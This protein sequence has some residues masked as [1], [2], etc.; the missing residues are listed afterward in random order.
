MQASGRDTPILLSSLTYFSYHLRFLSYHG[1]SF[2]V[3]TVIIWV[4]IITSGLI[5]SDNA[6][7]LSVLSLLKV[8]SPKIKLMYRRAQRCGSGTGPGGGDFD[9]WLG[10]MPRCGLTPQG[11]VCR[12]QL[13][14]GSLSSLMYFSLPLHSSLK[15]IKVNICF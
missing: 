2:F 6:N 4:N 8:Q 3:S 12:R 11:D 13:I 15:S 5:G 7:F 10:L 1:L 9:F 14:N